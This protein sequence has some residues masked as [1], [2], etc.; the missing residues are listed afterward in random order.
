MRNRK[1]FVER[2]LVFSLKPT[3]V[4]LCLYSGTTGL[5]NPF[6]PS[7]AL[8][9][10]CCRPQLHR[11]YKAVLFQRSCFVLALFHALKTNHIVWTKQRSLHLHSWHDEMI[12]CTWVM[13][14]GSEH[15]Q[16]FRDRNSFVLEC[17]KV[18]NCSQSNFFW[19]MHQPELSKVHTGLLQLKF[20]YVW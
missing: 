11:L 20:R 19:W 14:S 16:T 6:I 18:Y 1:V 4:F 12:L 15:I 8:T 3:C 2:R 7:S 9:H 10:R 5:M 17:F 13:V